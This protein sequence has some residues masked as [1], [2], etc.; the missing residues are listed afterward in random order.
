MKRYAIAA[1]LVAVLVALAFWWFSP[2]QV[3]KRRTKT[4][5]QTLTL[6]PGSGSAG[7]QMGTYSLNA[8]LAPQVELENPT[9]KEASGS[10]ERS[11]MESAFSWL[12]TAAKQ[13]R[14]E[15]EDFH[16]VTVD[17]D[18]AKVEFTL[19]GLVELPTYRPADGRYD[20]TFDWVKEE[21]GWRLKRAS[22]KEA[23]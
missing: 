5:L 6:E 20:A 7:R 22:W 16:S 15:L 21:D 3:V 10:F 14:F 19:K 12:C 9:I 23:D 4:L 17:G 8:L 13:T 2:A 1:L 18:Q 11:E